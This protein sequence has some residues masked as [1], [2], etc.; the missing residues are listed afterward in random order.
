MAEALRDPVYL[1]SPVDLA[2]ALAADGA[3]YYEWDL[4]ADR[5]VWLGATGILGGLGDAARSGESFLERIDPEHL[6]RRTVDLARH[7]DT[8]KAFAC[9]Y[10]LRGEGGALRWVSD[11]ATAELSAIGNPIRLRGVLRDIDADMHSRQQ[12]GFVAEYEPQT[13]LINRRRLRAVLDQFIDARREA[14][15]QG[16]VLL[17]AL[18]RLDAVLEA[19]GE[20][21]VDA[22]MHA[23]GERLRASIR[24]TD[25][26]GQI[27]TD[28]FALI[29]D[30]C[31]EASLTRAGEK[32]LAA[33][34][35]APVETPA[36][37]MSLAAA[38]GATTFPRPARR[39]EE[40]MTQADCALRHARLSGADCVRTF[41]DM[42]ARWLLRRRELTIAEQVQQALIEDRLILAHQPIV[43]AATRRIAFHEGLARIRDE[44]GKC[45]V[46]GA[47]IAVAERMGLMRQIDHRVLDLGLRA[48]ADDPA[49]RL[50][51]NVSGLTTTDAAWADRLA[52]AVAYDPGLAGRL[53]VE[54]T[55]TVALNDIE[56]TARFV[57]RLTELGCPVALDDF[58]AGFTSFRHLRALKPAIVKIDGGFVRDL[59]TS[60]DSRL[61]V[62]TLTR[63]ARGLG[64]ATVAECVETEAV[65]ATLAG[66]G[67][68]Y[69][70]G[71]HFG[72]PE[73]PA[74]AA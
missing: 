40:V 8:G 33:L 60:A 25:I 6:S 39:V 58:G 22:L 46:A 32:I 51:I 66:L 11:C 49:L 1:A 71:Y 52:A 59:A 27:G 15:G 31:A 3:L 56:E 57:A 50:A 73:V 20:D 24:K 61:F 63:L 26:V 65:T 14:G 69:F 23:A 35:A 41:Q 36:G 21:A 16:A 18:E 7:I 34:R 17:V 29:L 45:F 48:L 43:D 38:I 13:G 70:Q 19:Y 5:I 68:D 53:M 62:E 28:R 2:T 9:E 64:F 12:L 4:I 54:V 10:R 74:L 72:A 44:A 42:P 55:E 30:P 47:F 37:P 67:V